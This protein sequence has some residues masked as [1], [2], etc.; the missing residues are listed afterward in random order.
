[1]RWKSAR[2][3]IKLNLIPDVCTLPRGPRRHTSCVASSCYAGTC[4]PT[5]VDVWCRSPDDLRCDTLGIVSLG[6]DATQEFA[7]GLEVELHDNVLVEGILVV[8]GGTYAHDAV[9]SERGA[10]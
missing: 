10:T 3:K 6:H 4:Y 7:T 1:M 8:V 9:S 2:R 5:G